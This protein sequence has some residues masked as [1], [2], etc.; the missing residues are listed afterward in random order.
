MHFVIAYDIQQNRRRDK[1]MSTLK[2]F[3]L[4]VQYSVFECD[5]NAARLM[6]LRG[7]LEGLIDLHRDRVHIYPLCDAC[8]FR[9]E[10][11]GKELPNGRDL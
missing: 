8:F 2:D 11:M 4:R 9:S 3:G 5:L 10:S 6:E 1:V 7:R